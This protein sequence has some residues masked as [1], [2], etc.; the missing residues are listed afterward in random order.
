[1]AVSIVLPRFWLAVRPRAVALAC[2]NLYVSAVVLSVMIAH[3][4]LIVRPQSSLGERIIVPVAR[5]L[6]FLDAHWK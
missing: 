2:V 6:E 3:A 1:M 4:L 5:G